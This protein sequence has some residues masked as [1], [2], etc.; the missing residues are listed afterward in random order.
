MNDTRQIIPIA[1][2]VATIAM[3]IYMVAQLHAQ[4][5]ARDFSNAALA[6]VHDAQGQ[7]LLRGQ[8]T[9][10]EDEDGDIERKARLEPA[11]AD[12][13]A[14]GEA[15]VEVSRDTSATQEVEFSVR[16]LEPATALIFVIDGQ[17]ISR[18]TVD[19]RGR[20]E[21]ELDIAAPRSAASR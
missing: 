19:R 5:A 21:V 11:G 8:F 6:E 1:G 2:L 17:E 7:I 18:A 9:A 14:A 10:V 3:S 15:E 20:A 13:D 4:V 12:T 16:N